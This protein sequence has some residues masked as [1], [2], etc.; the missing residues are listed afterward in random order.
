MGE[1]KVARVTDR[2]SSEFGSEVAPRLRGRLCVCVC[3]HSRVNV[4]PTSLPSGRQ[5]QASLFLFFFLISI[6]SFDC[7]GS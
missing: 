2:S 7:A 6:Y 4:L 5:D 1:W 3:V